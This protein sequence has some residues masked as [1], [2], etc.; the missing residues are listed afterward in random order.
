MRPETLHLGLAV[1]AGLGASQAS[2]L[3][4]E[5]SYFYGL[6]PPVYP[7]PNTSGTGSWALAYSKAKAFVAKLTLEEKVNLTAG[8]TPT[9][10]CSGS[11]PAI[12]RLDFPGLCLTDAGNGVRGT[13]FVSA[14]PSGLHVGAS[15]NKALALKRGKAM[16]KE[17]LKKG[18]NTLLGPV[19]GPMF[20][21]AEGGRNWEG[22]AAD[23]YLSGSLA[24]E[25]VSGLQGSGVMACVKHYIG[26]EQE[27][28]RNPSGN[29]SAVSSN[30]DDTTLHEQYL[31]PFQEALHAGAA[32]IMCSYNRINNSYSCQNS[33]LLNGVLKEELGFQGFVVSD[34]YAQ[35]A[36]YPAA[37]AGL[38]LVM[39]SSLTYWGDNLTLSVLNGSLSE[40]RVDD[41]A[42]RIISSWY[43]LGQDDSIPSPGVGM[44]LDLLSPHTIVDAV[45]PTDKSILL[46]G[47]VEGHVLVKNVNGALPLKKPHMLYLAG[48]SAREP[49]ANSPEDGYGWSLNCESSIE[50]AEVFAS[51]LIG[52]DPASRSPAAATNGTIISG[53]GSGGVTMS[54]FSTPFN[55]LVNRA[56]EDGTQMFW[57]LRSAAPTADAAADVCIVFGNAWA[58]ESLDRVGLR[59]NATDTLVTSVA[60]SCANTV[61]VLHN[62]GARIVDAWIDHANVTAVIFAHL[63]G[64]YSG[65]ALVSLLYGDDDFS[66]RLP[67]SLPRHEDDYGSGL[68][69][70][71]VGAGDYALF[72]QADFDE[73]VYVDYRHFDR[74]GTELQYP[75]G[76]G[77]SYTT[78]AY[79]GLGIRRLSASSSGSNLTWATYPSGPVHQG[80]Q[81]D[82]WDV[83][84][85]VS[86]VVANTGSVAGQEVAQ[87]Y[88]GIPGAPVRQLR[89]FD[90]VAIGAGRSATVMFT[91]T[92]KDLSVWDSAAQKWK[93]QKGNYTV[94]VGSSSQTLPLKGFLVL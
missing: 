2:T 5:D 66:G 76:F 6:S 56:M 9:T 29:V 58:S 85:R 26:N 53:G 22:F 23:P 55:A 52:N 70:P 61:V 67:Y 13:D 62:A 88:V 17:A 83:V 18:V 63:P 44:P 77:L 7:T 84:A 65:Q 34:W 20:R 68:L 21:L 33:K 47:A 3:I 8:I 14:W 1:L 71:T 24:A 12:P 91:L 92:R 45:D 72:P 10:G 73:G 57:D 89:G 4:E 31:W 81:T 86:A 50:M 25:S 80:G 90:K 15:W 38:D 37:A 51:T 40:S 79:S 36:G 27:T 69:S 59:D 64:Q 11:V 49:A 82:L 60:D 30:I 16:G 78:F 54:V 28:Q 35:H 46:Q 48:Y 93:L 39:P 19:V 41:M 32:S 74:A 42:T 87:L 43:F 94:S 75:F